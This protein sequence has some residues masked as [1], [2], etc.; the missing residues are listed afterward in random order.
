MALLP[1]HRTSTR[2][3]GVVLAL[4]IATAPASGAAALAPATAVAD[5][6]DDAPLDTED[7]AVPDE[8]A[9]PDDDEPTAL[10]DED[11]SVADATADADGDESGTTDDDGDSDDGDEID[12]TDDG[13]AA[14]GDDVADDDAPAEEPLPK[15][16]RM[17]T[18]GWWTLFAGFAVGTTAGVFAG[19]A[20]RQE[21]RA[22][23]LATLFDAETGAQPLYADE[24]DEYEKILDRGRAYQRAAIGLAVVTGL[25]VAAAVTLFSVDASRRRGKGRTAR[26]WQLRPTAGGWQVRF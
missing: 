1:C 25:T 24:Q 17:Q 14:D 11:A 16:S 2:L 22:V 18:A 5:A 10:A 13:D 4:A 9:P 6:D 20:E 3:V 23:R 19:L 21:D 15:L 12:T 7:A 8:Q 26:R